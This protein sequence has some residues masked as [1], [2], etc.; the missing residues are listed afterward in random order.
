M[1]KSLGFPGDRRGNPTH[2]L[3]AYFHATPAKWTRDTSALRRKLYL[4]ALPLHVTSI[5]DS[6]TVV[7]FAQSSL[8]LPLFIEDYKYHVLYY[9]QYIYIYLYSKLLSTNEHERRGHR[10][11]EQGIKVWARPMRAVSG[12][13]G[14][15]TG[16]FIQRRACC[17]I[18]GQDAR[19]HR[20][21]GIVGPWGCVTCEPWWREDGARMA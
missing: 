8:S 3:P 17:D 6:I 1:G 10:Q 4:G 12:N 19:V 11:T 14:E 2:R 16:I 9:I 21:R 7:N 15:T 13:A 5:R 18:V 20:Q